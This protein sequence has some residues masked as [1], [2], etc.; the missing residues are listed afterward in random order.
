MTHYWAVNDE[1]IISCDFLICESPIGSLLSCF[2]SS[3]ARDIL[4][5]RHY[6]IKRKINIA[7]SF[8]GVINLFNME[9]ESFLISIGLSLWR[10]TKIF[11]LVM[12]FVN[13]P[14]PQYSIDS[15]DVINT[16]FLSSWLVIYYILESIIEALCV[17]K[18]KKFR[19][20]WLSILYFS[21]GT[22]Q[23][24]IS[25]TCWLRW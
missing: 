1:W 16:A 23:H 17:I 2:P 4:P 25:A 6:S 11:V 20:S 9:K 7:M 3:R 5:R 22:A 10:I 13:F 14:R 19:V 18:L 15:F 21:Y 8:C 12:G 24:R